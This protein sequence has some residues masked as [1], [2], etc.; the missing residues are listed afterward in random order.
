MQACDEASSDLVRKRPVTELNNDLLQDDS[1]AAKRIRQSTQTVQDL[2]NEPLQVTADQESNS[3]PVVGTVSSKDKSSGPV[4]QLVAMFGALVAQGEKAAGS[5]EIL[6]SSISSDLLAEVVMANMQHLPPTCPKTD[7]DD[8]ASETGYPSC[9]ASSVLPSIQLSHFAFHLQ[10]SHQISEEKVMDTVETTL[11]SSSVGD[12]SAMMPAILP[13]SVSPFPVVT[14]NGSSAVSL[15]LNSATEERVIPGVDSTSSTDEIQESHDA[16][17]SSNPEVNDSSQDHA[18][19]LGSLVPSNVLS[20]CSMGTDVLETQ[21][22]GVGIFDTSQASSTASLVTSCQYVLPKMMILDVNL[23]DEAKD[24]LQKVAFVRILDAY[25][26]VA[27]SGGL[28]ARC[29]LLVHLGIEVYTRA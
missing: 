10:K 11:L 3:V 8:V 21:S 23:T 28:D 17:H 20:T 13:A 15:S 24:Q 18:T 14:Q 9:L 27:I 5:L 25:K 1:P 2:P 29:S 6:I 16:S 22:T 19:S 26:Q 7:K 12:G 4:Q